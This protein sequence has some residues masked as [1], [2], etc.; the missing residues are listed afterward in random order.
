MRFQFIWLSKPLKVGTHEGNSP[1]DWSL[2]LV[3][4]TSP[5]DQSPFVFTTH[6]S[7]KLDQNLV[8]ATSPTNSNLFEFVGP[9]PG[10]SPTNYAWS[11]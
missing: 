11:L 3:P 8:P 9:V 10:T 7:P 1:C 2:R 5:G 6:F 4:A